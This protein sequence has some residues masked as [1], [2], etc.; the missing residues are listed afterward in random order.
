LNLTYCLL[1]VYALCVVGGVFPLEGMKTQRIFDGM[2][3]RKAIPGDW[4][5]FL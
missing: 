4:N 3:K 5:S 1:V 2:V